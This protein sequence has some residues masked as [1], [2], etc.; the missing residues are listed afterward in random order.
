[1][2]IVTEPNEFADAFRAVQ[3]KSHFKPATMRAALLV[4]PAGFHLS[5]QSAQDNRY[6]DLSVELDR[7]RAFAQHS[8]VARKICEL[9][10]PVVL[11]GG[12]RGLEDAIYPNNVYGTTADRFIVGRMF[13]QVRQQEANRE[14]VRD[15]FTGLLGR[16]LT[17][18][19]RE[20]AIAELTGAMAIDRVLSIGYCGLSNRADPEGARLM[21]DA[22][23]LELMLQFELVPE[24]YHTNIVLAILAGKVCVIYKPAFADPAVAEAI[25]EQY[26]TRTVVLNE[27]EKNH[28]AANCIAITEQ[29]LLMSQTAIDVLRDETR[30][31][32]ERCGFTIHGVAIDELEK[33]GGSLR[34][35]IA[36][37][38]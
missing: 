1:M 26:R 4:D 37:I 10:L 21:Y 38:F 29:D 23:D 8:G 5:P 11:F 14:D 13:H 36:E 25:H 16:P 32:L 18:L 22:F 9:G 7:E 28:F 34:C 24:E 12:R 35:L 17:D 31:V 19:S 6:I 27:A 3:A 20:H 15:F 30:E 33:G 2:G